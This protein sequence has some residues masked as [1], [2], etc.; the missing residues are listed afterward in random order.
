[1]I[2]NLSGAFVAGVVAA[3]LSRHHQLSQWHAPL[4]LG[5]LGGYTTFSTLMLESA[6]LRDR[7]H[8]L[9]LLA[10]LG[11]TI[12]LGVLVAFAGLML[13]RWM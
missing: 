11:V 8:H 2:I 3:Y 6:Q 9:H 7:A 4:V 13:G 12:I 5:F 10:Y 1:L